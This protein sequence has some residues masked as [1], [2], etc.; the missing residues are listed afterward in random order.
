MWTDGWM[1]KDTEI[2]MV[3]LTVAFCSFVSAHR[4][5]IDHN[6][7]NQLLYVL[8]AFILLWLQKAIPCMVRTTFPI[9]SSFLSTVV[10]LN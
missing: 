4:K 5:T 8:F 9:V 1:E 7:V 2:D 6:G 10:F 3:K